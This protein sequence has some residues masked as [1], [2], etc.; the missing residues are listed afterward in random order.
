MAATIELQ[1]NDTIPSAFKLSYEGETRRIKARSHTSIKQ[2]QELATGLFPALDGTEFAFHWQDPE[3]DTISIATDADLAEALLTTQEESAGSLRLT[4][5]QSEK[6]E[7]QHFSFPEP[8]LVVFPPLQH[9]QE[10]L[11]SPACAPGDDLLILRDF[12]H[13]TEAAALLSALGDVAT[14]A[15]AFI[16]SNPVAQQLL[17]APTFAL[18]LQ[19][20]IINEGNTEEASAPALSALAEQAFQ[21]FKGP[22]GERLLAVHVLPLLPPPLQHSIMRWLVDGEDAAAESPDEEGHGH[23]HRQHWHWHEQEQEQEQEQEHPPHPHHEPHLHPHPH[24]HPYPH[25]HPDRHHELD[26][27]MAEMEAQPDARPR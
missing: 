12:L 2:L 27:M 7:H 23:H 21:A 11:N 3:E 9:L 17:L 20:T 24:P 14:E 4:I 13:Q 15:V 25:P 1:R 19:K 10:Q 18:T 22:D 6:K 26:G 8:L 16:G 5:V